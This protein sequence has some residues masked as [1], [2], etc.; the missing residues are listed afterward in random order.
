M[1]NR[2]VSFIVKSEINCT[3][4]IQFQT[5]WSEERWMGEQSWMFSSSSWSEVAVE[6]VDED[7]HLDE[8][9]EQCLEAG[10]LD[11]GSK[12]QCLGQTLNKF[13]QMQ[14]SVRINH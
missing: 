13:L 6:T 9:F 10:D 2:V 7:K 14:S 5:S 12:K 1:L 4:K 3:L 11:E 8:I